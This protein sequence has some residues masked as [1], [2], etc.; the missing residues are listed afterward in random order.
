MILTAWEPLG[1]VAPP[2]P[3]KDSVMEAINKVGDVLQLLIMR[4]DQIEERVRTIDKTVAPW[5]WQQRQA[6]L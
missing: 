5:G 3:P 6:G 1:A 4:V 2:P